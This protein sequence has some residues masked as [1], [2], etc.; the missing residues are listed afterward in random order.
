MGLERGSVSTLALLVATVCQLVEAR[1][2]TAS[3]RMPGQAGNQETTTL[4]E[5]SVMR[6]LGAMGSRRNAVPW[7]TN[8]A[9]PVIWP[10]LLMLRASEIFHP[11]SGAIRWFRLRT[12]SRS[13]QTKAT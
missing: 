2:S 12:P 5:S 9:H 3:R 7:P 10:L 11:E 1:L 13:V 4:V 8:E 6:G